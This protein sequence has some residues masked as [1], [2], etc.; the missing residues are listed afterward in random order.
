MI[1][2]KTFCKVINDIKEVNK[3]LDD[4]QKINPSM[5]LAIVERYS[6][7]DSLISV[8]EEDMNIDVHPSY[9]S[10][11]SWWI[12]DNEFGEAGLTV[13]YNNKE[14]EIETPEELYDYIV[15]EKSLKGK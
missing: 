13:K 9:G 4:L 11:I 10:T 3:K 14:Q 1:S 12:Y 8:L 6:I 2:K 5:S 7:Q 15:F